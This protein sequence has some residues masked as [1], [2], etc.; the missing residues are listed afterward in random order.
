MR[1]GEVRF[2][3]TSVDESAAVCNI[4]LCRPPSF[5]I[6]SSS[7]LSFLGGRRFFLCF[8]APV[9]LI[10]AYVYTNLFDHDVRFPT[11]KICAKSREFAALELAWLAL[12]NRVWAV[13]RDWAPKFRL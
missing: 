5:C 6:A 8:S 3:G 2:F 11:I 9:W 4:N 7:R 12:K 13:E 10:I 1:R